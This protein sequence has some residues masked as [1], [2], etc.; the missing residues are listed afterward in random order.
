MDA[1]RDC[2]G[3]RVQ[4][5]RGGTDASAWLR[6]EAA[7]CLRLPA[8][9]IDAQAPLTR[10]GLDSL[11][12]VELACAIGKRLGGDVPESLLYDCPDL[13]SLARYLA[14]GDAARTR[15]QPQADLEPMLSD[16]VL[17]S[18]LE[19]LRVPL[20]EAV[21]NALVTGAT[22]LLGAHL[23]HAL[24]RTT[25]MRLYCLVRASDPDDGM[26]RIRAALDR[27]G[28]DPAALAARV[29]AVPGDLARPRLGIPEAVLQTLAGEIDAVYH[30]AAA[31]DWVAPY[32]LLRDANV[33][34]V[35]E[36]LRFASVA[37][38]KRFH[39]VS[40]AA[41][42]Y[43]S[44]GPAEI[45][46]SDD[47]LPYLS[48][49]HLGYAQSKCIAEALVRQAAVRGLPVALYRPV[50][51]SGDARS[52]VGSCDDFIARLIKGCIVMGSAPDLD[53]ALDCC[54]VDFAAEAIVRLSLTA[55]APIE[56]FHL[57]NPRPRHWRECVLWMNL[58]GY[59]VRLRP[60]D[61]WLARL[62]T[63]AIG[64]EHPLYP[65]RPFFLARPLAGA[66]LPEL[67]QEGR[68]SRLSCRRTRARLD[69]L[70]L[71]CTPLDA[72][73]LDRYFAAFIERG[74]LPE[75]SRRRT[76]KP[77]TPAQ[78]HDRDFFT[79]VLRRHYGDESIIVH[80]ITCAPQAS[81]HSII[82]EL[83]SWRYGVTAGL[84]RYV[85]RLRSG[86]DVERELKLVVKQKA[87]D[88]EVMDVAARVA[89]LCSEALGRAFA[90]FKAGT[91]L[92]G[93]HLRELA[94]YAQHDP[95]FQRHAPQVYG[96][97]R[98]DR[99]RRWM[100]V[101]EE[102]TDPVSMNRVDEPGTWRADE[103][104]A[105]LSGIAEVHAIWYGREAELATQPWLGPVPSARSMAAM[106]P[107]WRAAAEHAKPWFAT[108]A[109]AVPAL[110]R[111]LVG[112]VSE[113]WRALAAQPRTLIHNDFNPRNFALR[114]TPEGLRL[115]AYD[116]E[117]AT[118]GVPQHDLAELL[119]FVLEPPVAREQVLYYLDFHRRALE[120]ATKR[121]IDAPTWC[122]GFRLSLA[123]L[124][125]NRLPLYTMVHRFRAQ[126][127]L[128]RVVGTW[129]ALWALGL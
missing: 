53:W 20:P 118:L 117:L 8:R 56:V 67:Y 10:Y 19:P 112:S 85:V 116:W 44:S 29:R 64:R 11:S 46:E 16:S 100:L 4:Q 120:H 104:E 110:Q 38:R 36:L 5:A 119:C 79:G 92:G 90:R 23:V 49:I 88:L 72:A 84:Y 106:S 125:V 98:D 68:R 97:V 102:L 54:P 76:R 70:G 105:A 31:V 42:C 126:K 26:V 60:Y 21:R 1:G 3:M 115:C 65:L 52:G 7:A 34:S 66:T 33:L 51:L 37:R 94:V 14:A 2:G 77:G 58:Y 122:L 109:P 6:A 63:E 127:F 43:S 121:S 18:D 95:R 86:A 108:W 69:D 87:R 113:W 114:A 75:V 22:G 40:S 82:G 99:D 24:L 9:E 78:A 48:G 15:A 47:M 128:E 17:A 61:D 123:D 39:F 89:A 93:C 96:I 35:A 59:P 12:A 81:D 129:Y 27:Y 41:A 101:M 71:V 32:A 107:L 28:L 103:I 124:I 45:R 80:E 50:L 62:Q 55:R 57:A 25:D 83:T 74:F 30:S 73:L 111:R 91:G 13:A